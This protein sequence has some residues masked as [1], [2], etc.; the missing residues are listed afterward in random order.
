VEILMRVPPRAFTPPPEV[1][2]A[3]VK[4]TP[5]PAAYTVKDPDLFMA[6]VT[7]AFTQR[8]KRLRN[9]LVNGAHIMGIGNMKELLPDLPQDLMGRRAEEV[10]PEE[11]ASLADRIC[12]L[13]RA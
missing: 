1:E 11:Y 3:V 13:T 8:R 5:R 10:S 2:S 6:L 4:L 7:A 12:E 9:A